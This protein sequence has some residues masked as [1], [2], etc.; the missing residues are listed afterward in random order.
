MCSLG[1]V[2]LFKRKAIFHSSLSVFSSFFFFF[3]VANLLID[4]LADLEEV[5]GAL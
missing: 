5:L 1:S 2:L 3:M 4:N